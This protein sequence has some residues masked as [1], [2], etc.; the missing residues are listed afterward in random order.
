MDDKVKQIADGEVE[1]AASKAA[2]LAVWTAIAQMAKVFTQPMQSI[3]AE[4]R[5]VADIEAAKPV[6]G[7]IQ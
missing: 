2:F 4:E 5:P 6:T 3:R 7:L 1:R